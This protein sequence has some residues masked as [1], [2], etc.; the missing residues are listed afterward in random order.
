MTKPHESHWLHEKRVLRYFKGTY[1]YEIEFTYNCDV[2]LTGY[3][4]AYWVGDVDDIRPTT[5]YV[6]KLG[7]SVFS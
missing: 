6:F 3:P 7:S 5:C 1:N 4:D 2:E